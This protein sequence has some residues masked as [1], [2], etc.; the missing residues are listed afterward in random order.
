MKHINLAANVCG[1][2]PINLGKII[3]EGALADLW[4]DM[5]CEFV[6]FLCLEGLYNLRRGKVVVWEDGVHFLG[7]YIC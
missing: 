1:Y 5:V 6:P 2:T 4:I 3:K 7:L